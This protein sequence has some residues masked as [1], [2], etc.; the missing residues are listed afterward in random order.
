LGERSPGEPFKRREKKR[1]WKGEER[2]GGREGK[3]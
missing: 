1:K 3:P 2:E